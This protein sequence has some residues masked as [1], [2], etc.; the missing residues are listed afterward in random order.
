MCIE[1]AG[2]R[3]V[4]AMQFAGGRSIAQLAEEWERSAEW[5]EESIRR[6]LLEMIPKRDG[7]MKVSRSEA[8]ALRSGELQAVREAQAKLEW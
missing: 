7:G 3:E 1:D 8:R 5:V 4:V 2:A 6:S